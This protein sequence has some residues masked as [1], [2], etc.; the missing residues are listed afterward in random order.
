MTLNIGFSLAFSAGFARLGL[1]PHGGLALANSLATALECGLLLVLMRKRLTGLGLRHARRGLV[2][3]LAAALLMALALIAW[4]WITS[5]R[6][7]V[8]V[9]LGGV[10]VGAALYWTAALLLGVPEARMLPSLLFKRS[11][12][13]ADS[14]GADRDENLGDENPQRDPERRL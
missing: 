4:I 10:A 12:T 5:G 9:G 11:A 2:A 13:A 7:V 6:S 3:T 14:T 1:A 8:V